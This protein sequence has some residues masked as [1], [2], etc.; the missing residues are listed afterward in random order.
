M[1]DE[2]YSVSGVTEQDVIHAAKS[3][4]QKIFRITA[5]QIHCPI[6][7]GVGDSNLQIQYYLFMADTQ[8]V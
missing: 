5:T 6:A 1:R 4:L 7:A 2:R 8:Q 3:D